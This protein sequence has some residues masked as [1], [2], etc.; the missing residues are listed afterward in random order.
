[1]PQMMLISVVL[2]APLGPSSAED[3]AAGNM[4][5]QPVEGGAIRLA[6]ISLGQLARFQHAKS[7]PDAEGCSRSFPRMAWEV[8]SKRPSDPASHRRAL[9]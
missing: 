3:L 4:Q 9:A 6:L 8:A 1:M 2:P 5:I 7:P